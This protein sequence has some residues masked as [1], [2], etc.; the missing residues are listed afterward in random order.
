MIWTNKII[1]VT[2]A[3]LHTLII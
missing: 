2:Q 3:R 1:Q